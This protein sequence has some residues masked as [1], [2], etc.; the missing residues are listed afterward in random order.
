MRLTH[1]VHSRDSTAGIPARAVRPSPEQRFILRTG[2][3]RAAGNGRSPAAPVAGVDARPREGSGGPAGRILMLAVQPAGAPNSAPPAAD[4]L[5]AR[6]GV[7]LLTRFSR[8][9]RQ[10]LKG[11]WADA[12]RDGARLA[13]AAER[14]SQAL[15]VELRR[16]EQDL[17]RR[18]G[19]PSDDP[20]VAMR[21]SLG[22]HQKLSMTYL[23]LQEQM[24]RGVTTLLSNLLKRRHDCVMSSMRQFH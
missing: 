24:Q 4:R 1:A 8:S 19:P 2:D 5:Q 12:Q 11:A 23:A 16:T 7:S 13:H 3:E 10:A 9:S 6:D 15:H 17:A 18:A 22:L 21:E 14:G 20:M